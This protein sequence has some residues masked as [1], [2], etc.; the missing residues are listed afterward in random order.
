MERCD[1]ILAGLVPCT[2]ERGHQDVHRNAKARIW[3]HRILAG[4]YKE[5]R[6]AEDGTKETRDFLPGDVNVLQPEDK[7]RIDLIG[8]DCWTLFLAGDYQQAWNFSPQC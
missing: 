2:E 1:D 7:H 8:E 6:C 3:W 4:G 5:E